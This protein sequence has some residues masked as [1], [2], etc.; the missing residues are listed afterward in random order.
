MA[1]QHRDLAREAL[2]EIARRLD[3][4]LAE[5]A[6][7]GTGHTEARGHGVQTGQNGVGAL[8]RDLPRAERPAAPARVGAE[9]RSPAVLP[10][11][12]D[13]Q[14]PPAVLFEN[15]AQVAGARLVECTQVHEEAALEIADFARREAKPGR[16]LQRLDD[17]VAL[18]VA[19]EALET[20]ERHDVVADGAAGEQERGDLRLTSTSLPSA[21][22]VTAGMCLLPVSGTD[23]NANPFSQVKAGT[24]Q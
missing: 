23:N 11:A 22:D 18:V 1:A 3:D 20:D 5:V 8:R 17:L 15:P 19:D 14:R 16:P 24:C 13:V 6:H 9:K 2:H 12:V 10:R 4:G 7:H 21:V